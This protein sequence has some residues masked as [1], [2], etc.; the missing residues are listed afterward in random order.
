[1][2]SFAGVTKSIAYT[3]LVII[4]I[5]EKNKLKL[6]VA[7]IQAL[8]NGFDQVCNLKKADILCRDAAKMNA[9]VILFPEMWNI[10][11]E[12]FD[13]DIFKNDITPENIPE[14]LLIKAKA[15]QENAL[16]I[17]SQF[18]NHFKKLAGELDTAIVMTFLQKGKSKPLNSAILIDRYGK[19]VIN[20]SKV[21]T[22]DFSLEFFCEPGRE[23]YVSNLKTKHGDIKV[24]IMICFDR[25][26]P[27]SARELM[28]KGAELILIPNACEMDSHRISQLRTRAFENMAGVALANYPSPKC[29]GKS[30]AYSPLVYDENGNETNNLLIMADDKEGIFI[31]EF[32]ID[33]IR[34]FNKREVWGNKFRKTFAYRELSKS[35][36]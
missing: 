8:S 30:Q 7:L 25:E 34:T 6:R 11:Y 24:G 19:I 20:Y 32:D 10:G 28:L 16:G 3:V 12:P 22:C 27:E 31:A 33:K 9:D 13:V 5:F 1:M 4:S 2:N 17:D 29:N 18:T 14:Q 36:G 21:H 23:F 15:W 26:F 35:S